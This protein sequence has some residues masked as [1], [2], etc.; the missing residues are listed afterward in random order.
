MRAIRDAVG[1][2]VALRIDANGAWDVPTARARIEELGDLEIELAEQPCATVAELA[3]LRP[4]IAAPIV[5]DE[6]ANTPEAAANAFEAG[7]C[8]AVTIKLAK[9]G[10]I[11][12][13]LA[14]ADVAPSYLSSALDSPLGIAAAVHAA[15]ALPARG[16]ATGLAHG[17]AT[18]G[19][20]ADNVADDSA[21][22]GP[23]IDPGDRPGLGVE[24][25]ET[26]LERLRIR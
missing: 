22:R 15:Q 20:F 13:A 26:A 8:D 16:F 14:V 4:L 12:A 24:I 18:S 17:L 6:S 19:L 7:A 25:D 9:V 3:D 10:G 2:G 23:S 11:L 1:S 5:A 21:L